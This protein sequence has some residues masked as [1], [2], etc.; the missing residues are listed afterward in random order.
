M[1]G[2]LGIDAGS[3]DPLTD[4]IPLEELAEVTRR[5]RDDISRTARQCTP[6]REFLKLAN[7]L[8]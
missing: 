2:N 5:V 4:L 1:Y 7:A 3:W 6:H 8:A